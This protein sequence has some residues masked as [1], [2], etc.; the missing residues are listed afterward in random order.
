MQ[1]GDDLIGIELGIFQAQNFCKLLQCCPNISILYGVD[2]FTPYNDEVYGTMTV[3]EK[4]ANYNKIL[5]LHNIEYC[6]EKQK[7][8]VLI[9]DTLE[10]AKNF[11]D[12]SF[13]FIFL[14]AYL[15]EIQAKKELEVWYPKLKNGGIYCGHD[16]NDKGITKAVLSFR[17][18]NNI[19]NRMSVYDDAWMWYKN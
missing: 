8:K 17:E 13:D 7:A 3:D 4:Q 14:D 9:K 1:L 5:S 2:T 6:G 12:N 15:N 16:F 11:E 18:K 10:A 19:K